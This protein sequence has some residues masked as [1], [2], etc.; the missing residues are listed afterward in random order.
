MLA[1]LMNGPAA[2]W[3]SIDM[4]LNAIF[5]LIGLLVL[6]VTVPA[7][8]D[9]IYTPRATRWLRLAVP[10]SL[11]LAP[12]AVTVFGFAMVA[13]VLACAGL[14]A[15]R[16]FRMP[17]GLQ[18]Q[19]LK[20]TV[21]GIGGG[22][23]LAVV[24]AGLSEPAAGGTPVAFDWWA[25]T[26]EVLNQIAFGLIPAGI[27]VSLL[28]YRLNDADAAAGKSIGYAI[29]TVIVGAVWA[30]VQ[31]L[32]GDYTR[33][34]S[35][36]QAMTTAITTVIAALVFTPA[37]AY[38]LNWTEKK[39][40]PALV[41]LRKLPGK[42]VRWQTCQT[43]DELA[44][45][46]LADLVSG[47]GA[48]Y[49]AVLGDDGREWRVLGASGIE[50]ADATAKLALE[51]PAERDKDPFP[52]RIELADQLDEPDLL[53]IGP[54]SDGASFTRDEREAI[55]MIVEPLS[56]AIQAAALRERHIVKVE[57]S[58]AGIDERLARLEEELNPKRR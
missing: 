14:L 43:P 17:T 15:V 13:L 46:T 5:G 25:A 19:Q 9:G 11:L 34:W 58:L 8:P 45:A 52:I 20:W 6:V 39:F 23:L 1:H 10:L 24:S 50:P 32:V 31:M 51:R 35:G 42:L 57:T 3:A 38:V 36:N 53:A 37:R 21:L 28:E 56:N 55:A 27:A 18:K 49:A 48:A 16:Y 30:V 29:V 7:Y 12:L 44:A 2:F 26:G 4:P 33:R 22:F 54:R 40:Q 47:V 41:R